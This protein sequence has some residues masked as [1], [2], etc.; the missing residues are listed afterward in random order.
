M[1]WDENLTNLNYVLAGLYPLMRDTVR[2]VDASGVPKTHIAFSERGIDTWHAILTEAN[3]RG[4]VQAV[5]QAARKD[6][7][8][9]PVLAQAEQGQLTVVQ[10][11]MVDKDVVWK[12]AYAA[13][14]LEKIIGTQSTLVPI[15]FLE[16]GL[17]RARAVARV[18]L[19]NGTSGSGFVTQNNILITN[20]HVLH[21]PEEAHTASVQFNYQEDM[22]RR[23][24]APVTFALEPDSV[25]V[26]SPEDD[27]TLVRLRGDAA[28]E[29]GTIDV[30][31]A[32]VQVEDRVNIIQ[33]PGGGP[34]QISYF[35]NVVAYVD[36]RRVQYLTDTLPGSSG[37][38]VFNRQWQLVA[39][40]HSGGWI[41]EPESGTMVYRNEGIHVNCIA[42]A[43]QQVKVTPTG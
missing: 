32:Q 30:G 20:H 8:E 43:L 5:I 15:S 31:P 27:W 26:T 12:S 35:H 33:H 37:S 19:A 16:V 23:S 13:D 4:K 25:F 18:V 24:L 41:R 29:W 39:L 38:P 6:F 2:I 3:N 28:A 22:F 36:E 42:H 11:P 34:K 1:P 7:P 14:T 10:G 9:N 17:Q 40:H 21:T